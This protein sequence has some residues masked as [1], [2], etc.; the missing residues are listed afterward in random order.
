MID[1]VY[2]IDNLH[3][4]NDPPK[5]HSQ[6][7]EKLQLINTRVSYPYI[8]RHVWISHKTGSFLTASELEHNSGRVSRFTYLFQQTCDSIDHYRVVE[9][10]ANDIIAFVNGMYNVVSN[11]IR[12][13]RNLFP[14]FIITSTSQPDHFHILPSSVVKVYSKVSPIIR[15]MMDRVISGKIDTTELLSVREARG[16]VTAMKKFRASEDRK[17]S[18]DVSRMIGYCQDFLNNLDDAITIACK[19]ES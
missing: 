7:D 11:I 4:L 1:H 17:V 2:H 5:S 18:P 16:L 12:P 13:C 8:L 14:D 3:R 19:L 10:G 9:Y 15:T 6:I